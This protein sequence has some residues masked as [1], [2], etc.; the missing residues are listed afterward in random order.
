M[1]K[2]QAPGSTTYEK[3]TIESDDE[4]FSSSDSLETDNEDEIQGR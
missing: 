4:H 3:G 1:P 2:R